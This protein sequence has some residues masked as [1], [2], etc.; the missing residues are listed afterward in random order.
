[1]IS[2]LFRTIEMQIPGH[3][4]DQLNQN[5]GRKLRNLHF[6]NL[7][8]DSYELSRLKVTDLED[9]N[10]GGGCTF[11]GTGTYGKSLHFPF[12]FTVNLKLL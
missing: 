1:M 4:S 8:R 12:N 2:T 7:S 9:V 6:N 11:V 10:S 3:H 5:K